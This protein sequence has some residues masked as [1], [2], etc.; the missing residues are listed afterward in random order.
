MAFGDVIYENDFSMR[1]SEGAVPY[2]GWREQPY[3]TGSLVAANAGAPF[4]GGD[5]QDGW[6]RAN[7]S[8]L[9]PITVFDDGDN[10]EVAFYKNDTTN[11]F[12]V[13]KQRIGNTF[14][15]GVVAVQCD[16]R[17]PDS[18]VRDGQ[19]TLTLGDEAFFS[20]TISNADAL[21][22]RVAQAGIIYD[23]SDYKLKYWHR[24]ASGTNV[25]VTGPTKSTWYRLVITFDLDRSKWSCDFYNLGASHPTLDT[26]TPATAV[27]SRSDIDITS[28][29]ATEISSF[30]IDFY[31]PQ[32]NID[33]AEGL[34][35][36]G[37]YDNIRISHNGEECYVNDFNAR[38][39]RVFGGTTTATYEASGLL[40]T[41]TV[42]TDAYALGVDLYPASTG[43]GSVAQPIGIDGWR[44]I[45]SAGPRTFCAYSRA[46][47]DTADLHT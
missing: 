28:S 12:A 25:K 43:N 40:V 8:S 9:C 37:F 6:I 11:K 47:G 33:S 1:T 19:A 34:A 17:T 24:Q 38:R 46:Y 41:N 7:N 23:G 16:F 15:S 18:W 3:V 39:S 42:G 30:A 35:N 44:R 4:T 32:G 21:N 2:A 31:F 22:H 14:T 20:P 29:L 27:F 36:A 5:V 10:N 26:P 13:I 45:N